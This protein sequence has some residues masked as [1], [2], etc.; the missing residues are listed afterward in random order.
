M[1]DLSIVIPTYNRQHWIR[2]RLLSLDTLLSA[3]DLH[4]EIIISDNHSDPPVERVLADAP[5]ARVAYRIISPPAHVTKAEENLFFAVPHC[6]GRYV[7]V[8]GDDDPPTLQ[9]VRK[10]AERIRAGDRDLVLFNANR[11]LATGKFLNGSI[12]SSSS[13][14][15]ATLKEFV[16]VGGFWYTLAGFSNAV[17]RKPSAADMAMAAELLAINPIYSH[18]FWLAA[19]FWEKPFSF[20]LVPL[21]TYS[22]NRRDESNHWDKAA[23]REGVFRTFFWTLGFARQIAYLRSKVDIPPGWLADVWEMEWDMRRAPILD[24]ICF[25]V[26]K[27]LSEPSLFARAITV[28][29]LRETL[30]FLVA[31]NPKYEIFA[32]YVQKFGMK[33]PEDI[34]DRLAMRDMILEMR[35][36]P[37]FDYFIGDYRGFRLY[38]LHGEVFAIHAGAVDAIGDHITDLSLGDDRVSFTGPSEAAIKARI[39]G[40]YDRIMDLVEKASLREAAW[41]IAGAAESIESRIVK[42]KKPDAKS[43]K[44]GAVFMVKKLG[45]LILPKPI[46]KSIKRAIAKIRLERMQRHARA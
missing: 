7:W 3:T 35:A 45:V 27:E 32:A 18:V 42:K 22:E 34:L 12:T 24:N 1:V 13:D 30:D 43:V 38:R 44:D 4:Y 14:R 10:L 17:F 33:A 6:V 15:Y 23:Q 36:S 5:P 21:V 11:F 39:D 31:E 41:H 16:K 37:L 26:W 9:G 8:L 25:L 29:E 40:D 20:E 19:M 46:R 2:G 28:P